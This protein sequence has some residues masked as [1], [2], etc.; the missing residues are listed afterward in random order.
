MMM[1]KLSEIVEVLKSKNKIAVACHTFPDGD[2]LGSVVAMVLALRKLNKDVYILTKDKVMEQ[3]DFLPL[4]DEVNNSND[5][6]KK[7]TDVVLVLDCGNFDRVSFDQKTLGKIK[8][9]CVDHH[10][11]NSM[12]GDLNYVD[13]KSSATGEIV[14]DMINL[15]NVEIDKDISKC[16][17]TAIATDCGSFKF[18]NTTKRTHEIAGALIDTGIE[19][20]EISR[21]LFETKS[22][23]RIKLIS[24]ALN[25]MESYL[26]NKVNIMIIKE[27][28][29]L[30]LN[31]K[32]RDTGD[33]INFGLM[34]KDAEVSI[35][36]KE[37]EGKVRGSIRTK[38]KV[39]A[40]L[41]AES[42]NGGGHSRAAGLT[43][44]TP[45]FEEAKDI[46][47]RELEVY[48]Y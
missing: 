41:F 2:A 6:V 39:D 47:L 34:P 33:I 8:L 37:A 14:Y 25:S 20:Q 43:L 11:S 23:E 27:K 38:K 24:R 7:D 42:F 16:L 30:E 22:M 5:E 1:N 46:L 15:L 45:N 44:D 32:D 13:I 10:K 40:G 9:L 35:V 36:L 48:L 12:Y 31:V 19:F 17:Y 28:D 3:I 21:Q 26:N 4:V 29:F 18:E